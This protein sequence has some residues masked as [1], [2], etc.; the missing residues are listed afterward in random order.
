MRAVVFEFQKSLADTLKKNRGTTVRHTF[1]FDHLL[2]LCKTLR[3][4][5]P[6]KPLYKFKDKVLIRKTDIFD[7]KD[8]EGSTILRI[9]LDS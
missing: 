5:R 7:L 1:L 6:E 3:S 2:V 8:T 9:Y 4:S